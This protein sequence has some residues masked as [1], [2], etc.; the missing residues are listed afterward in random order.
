MKLILWL[1]AAGMLAGCA[2]NAGPGGRPDIQLNIVRQ[3]TLAPP[4]LALRDSFYAKVNEGREMRLFYQG[5]APG[6][7]GAEF[8]RFEVP[9]D[10]LYRKPDGSAFQPGDSI[11]VTV[12]V[13]DAAR[14]LFDFAPAGL[15]FDPAH[16]AH[17]RV[18]YSNGDQDFNGDGVEDSTDSEIEH[19]IDLWYRAT[20]GALWYSTGAVKFELSDEIDANIL[21]FSQYAVAW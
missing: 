14:F 4:L 3:D 9:G 12:T 20:P 18:S 10:G 21:T 2:E 15:R 17:M 1:L 7:S 6:D 16:P 8:L 19:E 13:V 11:L 5:A